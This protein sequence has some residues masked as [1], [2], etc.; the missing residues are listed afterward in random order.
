MRIFCWARAISSRCTE[1]TSSSCSLPRSRSV[2]RTSSSARS[3]P[4]RACSTCLAGLGRLVDRDLEP[5]QGVRRRDGDRLG[6]GALAQQPLTALG[7][8]GAGLALLAGLAQQPVDAA[9]DGAGALL[10]GAQREPGVHLALAGGLG[11]LDEPLA[12]AGVGLGAGVLAVVAGLLGGRE[13]LLELGEAGEVLV[14][15][16]LGLVDGLREPL[17]LALGGAG[18]RAVLAELLGDGGEGGVGLVELGQRDVDALVGLEPLGLEA[19]EVEAEPLAG[20]GGLEQRLGGLVDGALD[21]DQ[22]LL[23]VGPAGG[24]V[25]AEQVAVAGDGDDVGWAA[26]RACAASR[27]STTAARSSRRNSAGR[28]RS[29]HSMRSTA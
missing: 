1:L 27:S 6:H 18:L 23:G 20:R 25:G 11:G 5:R 26:T 24:E 4:L 12:V 14:A 2:A 15:G 21:L 19:A 8:L 9:V 29:G 3:R 7:G 16:G 28:S 13:S 17:G 10:A 22:A